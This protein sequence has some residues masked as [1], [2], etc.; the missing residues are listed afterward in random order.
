MSGSLT[1]NLIATKSMNPQ[2]CPPNSSLLYD[3]NDN[4]N[5]T[6]K[7]IQIFARKR[8]IRHAEE[9]TKRTILDQMYRV[10][11]IKYLS[12]YITTNTCKKLLLGSDDSEVL[13]TF[14]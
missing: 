9:M 11:I 7:T 14:S 10:S 8:E 3:C 4:L 12:N 1:L 5:S 6:A 13:K 2:N